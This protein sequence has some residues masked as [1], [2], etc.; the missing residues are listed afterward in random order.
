MLCTLYLDTTF[1]EA[2]Q[3]SMASPTV[4]SLHLHTGN[5]AYVCTEVSP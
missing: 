3:Q 5:A 4:A 1:T 2:R